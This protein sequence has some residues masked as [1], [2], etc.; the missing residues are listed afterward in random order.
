MTK[1]TIPDIDNF[2]YKTES[3]NEVN[4]AV[5]NNYLDSEI[6]KDTIS[7]YKDGVL[8]DVSYLET[9]IRVYVTI[10]GFCLNDIYFQYEELEQDTHLHT[11]LDRISASCRA[12][13]P[14]INKMNTL[15]Q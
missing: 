11:I 2:V 14:C 15:L 12:A 4:F 1:L 8:I 7:L 9:C 3:G 5:W 6:L 13:Q 10:H